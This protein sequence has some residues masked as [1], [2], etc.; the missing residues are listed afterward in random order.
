M[1]PSFSIGGL[2]RRFPLGAKANFEIF[3]DGLRRGGL[4]TPLRGGLNSPRSRLALRLQAQL[5]PLA[6]GVGS[7]GY[8]K[9]GL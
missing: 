4:L 5:E 6:D 8:T 3:F 1:E 2:A 7:R 9:L